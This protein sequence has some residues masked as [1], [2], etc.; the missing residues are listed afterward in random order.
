ML[1]ITKGLAGQTFI[2]TLNEAKTVLTSY[3]LFRIQSVGTSDLVELFYSSAE[4]T[5]S[6][7]ERFNE[8][9]VDE[10]LFESVAVGQYKYTVYEA[11]SPRYGNYEDLNIVETGQLEVRPATNINRLGYEA[12]PGQRRGYAG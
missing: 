4:D 3:Y 1:I 11:F 7:P 8:F 5:S 9:N 12:T 10:T 6:Y 2:V